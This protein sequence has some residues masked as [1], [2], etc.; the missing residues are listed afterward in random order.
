MKRVLKA[1]KLKVLKKANKIKIII[2]IINDNNY[3]N[4]FKKKTK[5]KKYGI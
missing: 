4:N 3:N 2:I 1:G 5:R